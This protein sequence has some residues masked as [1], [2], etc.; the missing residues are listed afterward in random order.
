LTG[1]RATATLPA[2]P[3]SG[4]PSQAELVICD[5]TIER[6]QAWVVTFRELAI[7]YDRHAASVHAFLHLACTVI[8]L[9][10]LAH[11]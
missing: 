3:Y 1:R 9:R 11:A 2:Q 7:R 10:F 6:T 4:A 8:C 5:K